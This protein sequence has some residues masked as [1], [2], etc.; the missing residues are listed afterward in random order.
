MRTL[1]VESPGA[2]LQHVLAATSDKS[3]PIFENWLLQRL[4]GNSRK[5]ECRAGSFYAK[6]YAQ[7]EA[8]VEYYEKKDITE[9]VPEVDEIKRFLLI[10]STYEG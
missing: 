8:L 10:A 2:F 9:P 3:V 6:A 7:Y 5:K 4:E 1:Y